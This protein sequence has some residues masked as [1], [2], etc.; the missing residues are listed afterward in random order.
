MDNRDRPKANLP[1]PVEMTGVVSDIVLS[2]ER[3]M[4]G[5]LTRRLNGEPL[6]VRDDLGVGRAFMEMS[7][8]L[9]FD[10]LRLFEKQLDLWHD[11]LVLWQ[12]AAT[13]MLG[14]EPE[15]VI[16]PAK[17]DRRF[18]DDAWEE[19]CTFDMIKQ[20][21]LLYAQWLQDLVDGVEGLDE[22]TQRKVE[23]YTRQ[24]VDALAPTNFV[25]TN[26]EALRETIRS[27]GQNLLKG[28]RNLL[29]D[30]ERG[31]G[32]VA[33]RMTDTSAFELGRNVAVT[34]GKVV[35]Q[36]PMMQLIQ[37]TPTTDRVYKRPLLI[38]PPWINKFYILDLRAKNSFI[39][40]A[41]DQGHTVFIISWI[42]PDESYAEVGFDDYLQ[43][44]TLAALE[45]I[46]Q[47]TGETEV[48]AIGYCLGG[49]LLSIT[50]GW[51]ADAGRQPIKSVSLFTTLIDFSR[52]GELEV[53]LDEE[54]V[55]NLEERMK[56]RGYLEGS[57][58]ATTFNML[59]ANDLIWSFAVNN[60]LLGKDPFPFDLLYWNSDS[61][62]MPAAM[63]SFYLRNMYLTNRLMQ[64]GELVL[65]GRPI[66]LS[67]IKVPAYFL[68]T[69]ED[70]IAPWKSTYGG[71]QILG[72]PV[73]F[74]LGASGHI[75]GVINP[76]VANKY[77]YWTN[78]ERIPAKPEA[79]LE[80]AKQHPGSWWGDWQNWVIG[81]QDEQVA[82]RQ[83]GDGQLEPIENAPGAYVKV[84]LQK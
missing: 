25:L 71:T 23:F 59:R 58:M 12:N 45:A 72:G 60:Y 55:A 11:S 19:S 29:E 40:W 52:P 4:N 43:Q 68:S 84:R 17:G 79:W 63:H 50:L 24:V 27:G 18:K 77:H 48:N 28:W 54:Q 5:M 14:G 1:D 53:F 81:Q 61:T 67:R 32:Q 76:P 8:Q 46:E 56:E 13:R 3:L 75:A 22:Q 16:K 38:V 62:R 39:K 34:P 69:I 7:T 37:Y 36:N 78:G 49:T 26:P 31:R 64:P 74:V 47:A 44:G 70:H 10:P 65:G 35:Y 80:G 66:D 41:V 2:S 57:E 30:L 51:L 15:P 9:L 21:Y 33:I 82:A 42:N 83:P 73:R 20:S 6:K